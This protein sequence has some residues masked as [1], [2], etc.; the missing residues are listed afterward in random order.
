MSRCELGMI[1]NDSLL[2]VFR[3]SDIGL[4]AVASN[5]IVTLNKASR[6]ISAEFSNP[7]FQSLWL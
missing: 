6:R 3:P 5:N 4:A 1:L 2:F 7:L